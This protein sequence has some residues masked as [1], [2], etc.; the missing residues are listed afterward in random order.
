MRLSRLAAKVAVAG[1]V[2]AA[3]MAMPYASGAKAEETLRA[4]LSA[5]LGVLDPIATTSYATR[6]FAYMVYDTL[7]S[8]DSEGNF[9]PQMLESWDVSGDGL[10]YNFTLRDGL[11]F[12]DGSAVTAEDAVASLNRW[13][14][15]DS[16]GKRMKAAAKGFTV[17]G[18]KTFELQLTRPFGHVI[19]ALGKPSS[20]VPVIMP[21]RLASATAPTDPVKEIIGS[22]PFV[23]DAEG[24]SPGDV[25]KF[26]KNQHYNPRSEPAD[27]LA[28][29]KVARFDHVEFVSIP[30][31][32][33]QIAALQAGE[34]DYV[35]STPYDFIEILNSNPDVDVAR[36]DGVG[37]TLLSV[38]VNHLTPP[39]DNKEVRRAL[40]ALAMTEQYMAGLG[41][42]KDMWLE[43][44][45]S[46]FMC[47]ATYGNEAGVDK[48]PETG[49][50]AAK[51]ILK[52]AGYNGEKV[53]ILLASSVNDI[54]HAGLVLEGLM[55]Q[56]G[57]NVEVQAADWPTVAKARWSKDPVSEGGWS[58]MP[59]TWS[60]YDMA[61][62]FTNYRIANN[63][64][65]G[66]AGWACVDEITDLIAQFEA[67]SDLAKRKEITARI[68][69]LSHDNVQFLVLG[70]Y[71]R[72]STYRSNLEGLLDNG[73][74]IFWNVSRK[75]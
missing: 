51:K 36:F 16:L 61:S 72:S 67:E 64:T 27:G 20:N 2:L 44:C 19:A 45:Y 46:F 4:V 41:L 1:G 39:F 10:T 53:R 70:Q 75:Q 29:G 42:P 18:D 62:P 66:Y 24:W 49:I 23:F 33:T 56:A 55:K 63:C 40:Q 25:A 74:P 69:E 14:E 6:T 17:T 47:G 30:D 11:K 12:S 43:G 50:D 35:Q 38:V 71:S 15:R 48:L 9:Q 26:S 34:V 37:M 52:D 60:G 54:N 8:M 13:W 31:A 68:Q 21:A 59:V 7:V 73:M 5:K 65:D 58:L 28:G 57:F 32:A 3:S 22:G